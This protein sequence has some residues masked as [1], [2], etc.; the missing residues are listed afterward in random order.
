MLKKS[1]S[2]S[3]PELFYK[4]SIQLQTVFTCSR[5]LKCVQKLEIGGIPPSMIHHFSWFFELVA[6]EM[7]L[8]MILHDNFS[9][10]CMIFCLCCSWS[11]GWHSWSNLESRKAKLHLQYPED[12]FLLWGFAKYWIL[13]EIFNLEKHGDGFADFRYKFYSVLCC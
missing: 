2:Q 1:L 6:L 10:F 3:V 11:W 5:S 13:R 7:F 12:G 4:F 9:W 8:C